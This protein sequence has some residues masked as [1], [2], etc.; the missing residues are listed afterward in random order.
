M[1]F[2]YSKIT[3]TDDKSIN[4]IIKD[5]DNSGNIKETDDIELVHLG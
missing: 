5:L 4:L 1:D 3:K 2:I